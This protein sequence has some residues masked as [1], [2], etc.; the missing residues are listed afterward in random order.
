MAEWLPS[1]WHALK[2]ITNPKR[3]SN[4]NS[5]REFQFPQ[6]RGSVRGFSQ[7]CQIEKAGDII[8]TDE[9]NSLLHLHPD[10]KKGD[11]CY[12][13]PHPTITLST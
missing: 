1:I 4:T 6:T 7:A 5:A 9:G 13:P 11:S 2:A 8:V 3:A 10:E 12:F